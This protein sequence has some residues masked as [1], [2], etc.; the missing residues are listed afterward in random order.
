[1]GRAFVLREVAVAVRLVGPGK[2]VY[3]SKEMPNGEIYVVRAVHHHLRS[4][5]VFKGTVRLRTVALEGGFCGSYSFSTCGDTMVYYDSTLTPKCVR[6]RGRKVEVTTSVIAQCPMHTQCRPY[7]LG[8]NMYTVSTSTRVSLFRYN[9][10]TL[11]DEAKKRKHSA[12]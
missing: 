7:L 1:M 3:I 2:I 8:A 10:D 12:I 9:A 6:V 5:D 4:I 11:F